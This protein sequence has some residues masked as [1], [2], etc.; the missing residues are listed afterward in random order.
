[1]CD[2]K[3]MTLLKNIYVAIQLNN[4]ISLIKYIKVRYVIHSLH[5]NM[6]QHHFKTN[7]EYSHFYLQI[8]SNPFVY[9]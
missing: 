8:N 4:F 7:L 9:C 1:M 6:K 5:S 2:Q 3:T